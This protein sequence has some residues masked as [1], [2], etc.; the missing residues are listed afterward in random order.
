M[1]RSDSS[2]NSAKIKKGDTV[3]CDLDMD[4]GTMNVSIN[5][6]DQG[7]CFTGMAGLEVW[8]AVQFYSSNRTVR[9]LKLEGPTAST[10]RVTP[11]V[12]CPCSTH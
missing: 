7:V 9:F 6:S 3:R 2:S 1:G 12:A 4:A 10:V 11:V 8:P 5:G